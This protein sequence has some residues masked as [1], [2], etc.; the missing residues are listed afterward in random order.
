MTNVQLSG[1]GLT[2]RDRQARYAWKYLKTTTGEKVLVPAVY[3]HRH[4]FLQASTF[5]DANGRST[6]GHYP[7]AAAKVT[8]N[9]IPANGSIVTID[10]TATAAKTFEFNT[11]GADADPAYFVILVATDTL[12]SAL[13][14]LKAKIEAVLGADVDVF[15]APDVANTIAVFDKGPAVGATT[16][17]AKSGGDSLTS[18]TITAIAA[19]GAASTAQAPCEGGAAKLTLVHPYSPAGYF[20]T[21]VNSAIAVNIGDADNEH[22]I[23]YVTLKD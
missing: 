17:A 14:K 22:L 13:S 20:E 1:D 5:L 15:Y 2:V 8:L 21:P 4:R 12:A 3:G 19:G 6:Y 9:T 16:I 7:P 10:T 11:A 18:I 23:A